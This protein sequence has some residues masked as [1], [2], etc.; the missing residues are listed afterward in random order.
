[1]GNGKSGFIRPRQAQVAL[2][3]R[4]LDCVWIA[5]A[6]MMACAICSDEW[7]S[8]HSLATAV[9]T[10]VFYFVADAWKVYRPWRATPL[11]SE[12]KPVWGAW[13]VVVPILL[14][15]GFATKVSADYSRL[16][17]TMWFAATPVLLSIWRVCVRQVL[18]ALR[19]RGWNTR[20]VAI[21]G[22]TPIGATLARRIMASAQSGM[23]I[24][25]YYDDR[26]RERLD[27]MP[28]VLG[29]VNGDIDELV[30]FARTGRVDIV[31]I[32]LPLRAEARINSLVRRLADTTASVYV[33]AD[34]FVFDL[35]HAQWSAVEGIPTV[36]IFES[37]FLGVNDWLKRLED[38][39]LGT[40]I[41]AI[42]AIPMAI[43]ALGVKLSSPGPVLF[44]QRRYGLNGQP[45]EVLKFRSMTTCED[46]KNVHQA[47]KNDPRVTPF[48]SFLRRTSL[49]ELPQFFNVLT[50]KMSIVGPRP[51]AVAH[52][53]MY[54][55]LIQGYMLRHKVKPGITGWAQV[56]G[57]RGETDTL[58][59]MEKRVEHDL[60]YIQNWGL[61]LDLQIIV[62]TVFGRAVRRNAY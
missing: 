28:S 38:V 30:E 60:H 45:I 4:A 1:M 22:A 31:Y 16:E 12:I 25:G 9:A 48:G 33:V 51:H 53:E 8:R 43:I 29:D 13:A 41:M 57:W 37:P 15:I 35:A 59:K 44:R 32:T 27:E 2:L 3:Q 42:V 10:I 40:I 24:K 50:G 20:S 61:G 52:N 5:V 39:V 46:G 34:S 18:Q 17:I 6:L 7:S 58:D 49:D 26:C 19:S 55:G 54:R 14:F 47:T 21:V 56:N 23:L 36:S 11:R 62:M